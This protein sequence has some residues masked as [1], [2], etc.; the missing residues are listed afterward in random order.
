MIPQVDMANHVHPS[1]TAKGLEGSDFVVLA[2][3]DLPKGEQVF[4]SY[5]PLPN[6]AL[7]SQ[8]GFVIPASPDDFAL[9]NC[10]TLVAH[11]S[12]SSASAAV[13]A[14]ASA[15]LLMRESGGDVSDWQPAGPQLAAAV[16]ELAERGALPASLIPEG[17]SSAS[18]AEAEGKAAYASLLKVTLDAYSTTVGDDRAKLR[19]GKLAPRA[20]LALAWRAEQKAMLNRELATIT[21]KR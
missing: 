8:F 9:V 15:G 4:L 12:D 14:V 1:N 21:I 19:A 20:R 13:A 6:Q 11:A 10:H 17:T 16:H 3:R 2:A 5:G 7:L 18:G